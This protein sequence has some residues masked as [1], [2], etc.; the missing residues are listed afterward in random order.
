MSFSKKKSMRNLLLPLTSL[1]QIFSKKSAFYLP[2]CTP[3]TSVPL[4]ANL[5]LHL[6]ILNL[7]LCFCLPMDFLLRHQ[8]RDP[9]KQMLGHAN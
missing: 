4:S 6:A 7:W 2:K 1:I 3:S 8:Q 5:S 9:L